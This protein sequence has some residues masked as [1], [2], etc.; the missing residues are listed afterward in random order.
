MRMA[1]TIYLLA[2]SNDNLRLHVGAVEDFV[3]HLDIANGQNLLAN[4]ELFDDKGVSFEITA[5]GNGAPVLAEVNPQVVTEGPL[6]VNRIA[7]ALANAQV[8]LD[9]AVDNIGVGPIPLLRGELRTVLA[10]LADFFGPLIPAGVG[11]PPTRGTRRHN[12]AHDH[13]CAVH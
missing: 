4:V 5:D 1:D 8:I 7:V 12:W 3:P 9:T 6:L 2:I 10:A 11:P 13:N